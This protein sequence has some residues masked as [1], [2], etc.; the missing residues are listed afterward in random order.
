LG[1]E[2]YRPGQSDIDAV[3]IVEDRSLEIWGDLEEGSARLVALNHVYKERYHIPKSFDPFALQVSQLYPPYD[4][5]SDMLPLEIARLKVQGVRV[6][7]DFDL[8]SVPMPSAEDLRRG[9][10]R[11]EAW[12]RDE[13]SRSH[14]IS[15]FSEAACVNTI[16]IHLGRFLRIERGV[17]EFDKRALVAAYLESDPPFVEEE[18]FRLVQASLAMRALSAS[19]LGKLRRYV[20]ELRTQ[21]NAYLGIAD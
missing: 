15:G 11:F 14:P 9:A 1:G 16:L 10:A 18:A 17:L 2:Y 20:V 5:E 8:A 19:E 12:F 3:L 4:P 6:Y 7:G 13:F 21:M